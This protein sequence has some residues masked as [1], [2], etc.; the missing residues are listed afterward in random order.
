VAAR[1]A[2]HRG[3]VMQ[4]LDLIEHGLAPSLSLLRPL[5]LSTQYEDSAGPGKATKLRMDCIT[6]VNGHKTYVHQLMKLPPCADREI[7][8][9]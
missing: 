6:K 1:I 4:A 5:P 8:A 2:C 9:P 7:S 3:N